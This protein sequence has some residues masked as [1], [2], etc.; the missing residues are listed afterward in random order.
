[1][2]FIHIDSA[3][4]FHRAKHAVRGD[5]DLKIGMAM[6]VIFNSIKKSWNDFDGDHI[7][8]YMEGSSWRKRFYLPYKKNREAARAALTVKEQKEEDLFFEAFN[9]FIQFVDE[10]TNCTVL[11]NPVLEADDLI[12][13]FIQLHPHDKHVIISSDSDF[14]QLISENVVQYNGIAETT[15]TINGIFDKKN[16]LIPDKKAGFTNGPIDP[17]WFLFEKCIR[18]DSTDN[19]F[20]AFPNVRTKSSKNKIGLLEA[21]EDKKNKG[22][23]WNNLM[24][25]KWADHEGVEHRVHDDYER[26]RRLIDLSY[27][28]DEIRAIIVQTIKDKLSIEKNNTQVGI[29]LMKFC[30][31]YDL[32]KVLDNIQQYAD[33]S[34]AKYKTKE[35]VCQ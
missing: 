2:A 28:P 10:K 12:A 11:H 5:I 24:L 34:Q 20:S 32:K 16:K 26:N 3:N 15:T 19:V 8:F 7:I 4:L 14:I 6:H 29:K 9:H 25:Q 22:Y 17:Q 1:M 27:Q 33:A 23:A 13:G 35:T 31:L 18:G 21:Y 30:N